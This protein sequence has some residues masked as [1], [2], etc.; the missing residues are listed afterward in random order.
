MLDFIY[1]VSG[2]KVSYR[3]LTK[4]PADLTPDWDFGDNRGKSNDITPH[5]TYDSSGFY[6]VTLTVG[7]EVCTKTVV[8]SEYVKTVLK[9]SIYNLI[10]KY[11]PKS[12]ADDMTVDDKETYIN[13]WQLYIQPLVN[14]NIPLEEYSNE[15]YYEGLENQLI[16]EL[17]VYDLIYSRVYNLI[18]NTGNMLGDILSGN[19]SSDGE[20]TNTER[21][22]QITTGPTEVQFYDRLSDSVSSLYKTYTQMSQPGG[23]L[24]ELR[25]NICMLSSRLDIYLPICTQSK[26]PVVPSVVNRRVSN[27]ISG[28]NPSLVVNKPGSS[29]L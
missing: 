21:V 29:L 19:Q 2:L 18:L 5:Y 15:L 12:I 1:S 27:G 11:I 13:K 20:G 26:S 6:T 8:V 3:I 28:P 22:K 24:D 17:A 7:D 23:L 16:M 25:R 9:G 14:H 4:V 10:D